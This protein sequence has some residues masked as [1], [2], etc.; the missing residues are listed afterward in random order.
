LLLPL[1]AQGIRETLRFS[2]VSSFKTVVRIP[3]AG[4]QPVARPLPKG[5]ST[6]LVLPRLVLV[7]RLVW[8]LLVLVNVRP[9]YFSCSP[10]FGA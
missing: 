9:H 8:V 10:V 2:S 4:D 5:A 6:L 7:G 1:E 3:W